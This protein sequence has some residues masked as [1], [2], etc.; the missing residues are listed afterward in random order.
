MHFSTPCTGLLGGSF[1]PA[2]AGHVHISLEALKRLKLNKVVWLV[3]PH[4]PLKKKSELADFEERVR[5]AQAFT[6]RQPHI[7]VSRLEQLLGTRYTYDSL[8]IIKKLNPHTRFIWLMGADNLAGFHRWQ[9]WAEI[10]TLMPIVVFDRAPFSHNALRSKAALRFAQNRRSARE[11][12]ACPGTLPSW[13]YVP[14]R[15]H[16]ASATAI[17][18]RQCSLLA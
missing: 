6:A 17:R 13:A 2:H 7:Q 8:R 11:L 1:N 4:N 5:Y 16:A 15:R 9:H 3:A 18:A 10:F 12:A 14:M